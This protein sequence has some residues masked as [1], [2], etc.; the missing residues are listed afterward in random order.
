MKI[1]PITS[2][3]PIVPNP[4]QGG[5]A[6]EKLQRLKAI[7]SG[8][9]PDASGGDGPLPTNGTVI[10]DASVEANGVP[11]VTEPLSPQFA[12]LAK[13]RRA[14]QVKEAEIAQREQALAEREKTLSG[15]TRQELETRLKTHALSTLQELG[16]SYDQLTQ[17]ILSQQN[18]VTPEILELRQEI[19]SLREGVDKT[20]T[21]KEQ[22]AEKA[23]LADMKRNVDKLSFQGDDFE[24]IR[25]MKKQQDVVDLIHRNWKETGEVLDE[26]EAMTLIEEELVN[27]NL[28]IAKL[29]KIQGKL[30]PTESLPLQQKGLTT[31][32]NKDHARPVMDRK[33]R[34]I[35]AMQGN[36]KR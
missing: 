11:E 6:P 26:R 30:I 34:A 14:A 13:Q 9:S 23:V 7:A 19:K 33:Q 20:L 17:E 18:G 15:P 28:R 36:L 12:M 16:I 5:L 3:N 21:D 10:S 4:G 35:L 32:T 22:Q 2:G 8:Q 29:K 24:M 27:D 25:E 1:S 31:L